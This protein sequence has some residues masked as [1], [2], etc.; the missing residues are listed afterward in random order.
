M[1]AH[2]MLRQ[3]LEDLRRAGVTSLPTDLVQQL[4][5]L[6][7]PVGASERSPQP[8]TAR[9]PSRP[10]RNTLARRPAASAAAPAS[11]AL[12]P[13]AN[14]SGNAPAP[15]VAPGTVRQLPQPTASLPRKYTASMTDSPRPC[16]SLSRT[17]REAQLGSLADR[18]AACVRCQE[19][20]D[21]RTQTVFGV[22]NPEADIMF[23][24]EAPGADEDRQGEPFVGRAGQKLNDIIAACRLTREEIYICNI[25][26][27]RPPGNRT[28]LPQEAANCREYLDGQIELVDPR[29]IVCWGSCAAQN[30]LN[31]KVAIG[32]L[33]G[34]FF[35]YRGIKVLC[36]YHPS[37]LLRQP[38]AKKQV[39]EDM[40]MFRADMGVIL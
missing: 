38:A 11:A 35:D 8:A 20:A 21:T 33:R 6:V 2:R 36:T 17:E 32:K 18:V 26:R 19:L 3:R 15:A 7:P 12:R 22:G 5:A 9:G 4:E 29:Y 10:E 37:Y 23:I 40:K 28:P 24:G 30:L 39:W 31:T 1:N 34:Q 13:T 27:C 25:L 16:S 14:P